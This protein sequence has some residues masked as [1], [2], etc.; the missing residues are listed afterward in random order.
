LKK[1]ICFRFD[2]DTHK[3]AKT[4]IPQLVKL[5]HEKRVP[6]TFFVNC[7]RAIDLFESIKATCFKKNKKNITHYPQ[8]SARRKFG[9]LEYL[10]CAIFNPLI[11]EYAEIEIRNAHSAGHEIG[12]HGGRNHELWGRLVNQWSDRKIEEE[13]QWGLQQLQR[14][15]IQPTSFASPCAEGGERVRK[16]VE[17]FKNFKFISDDLNPQSNFI[18]PVKSGMLDL[19]T[20]LCGDGGVAYI[21]QL[22]ALGKTDDEIVDHFKSRLLEIDSGIFY[23]HP[24]FAGVEALP[25]L[26]KLVDCALDN[27][28]ELVTLTE[29]GHHYEN[30]IYRKGT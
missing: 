23:E 10:R 9:N 30:H 14:I 2:V 15:E 6:F 19:P 4:G 22:V 17:S 18:K 26:G 16:A 25:I 21:E 8:L 24:Y 5:A 29:I 3:C 13:I 27:G 11:I 20:N 12:L 7:G 1:K 28:F